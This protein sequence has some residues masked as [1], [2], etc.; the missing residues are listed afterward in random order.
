M[1]V[2]IDLDEEQRRISELE[3]RRLTLS[4]KVAA[5][6][7]ERGSLLGRVHLSEEEPER[8]TAH[9]ALLAE[10]EFEEEQVS[11]ALALL[12]SRFENDANEV[13]AASS[14]ALRAEDAA[15]IEADRKGDRKA[16]VL[17]GQ[18]ADLNDQYQSREQRRREIFGELSAAEPETVAAVR[19][20]YEAE[21]QKVQEQFIG[22]LAEADSITATRIRDIHQ[23][24]PYTSPDDFKLGLDIEVTERGKPVTLVKAP[25][26]ASQAIAAISAW[27]V[28]RWTQAEQDRRSAL[29]E[30]AQRW[31]AASRESGC[32]TPPG[33][34]DPGHDLILDRF[35]ESWL[36]LAP[37]SLRPRFGDALRHLP[38]QPSSRHKTDATH[39]SLEQT[40][41]AAEKAILRRLA[42]P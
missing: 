26:N 41:L 3:Q 28:D 13:K 16:S 23:S 8:L 17:L 20:T 36:A 14:R 40:R 39:W 42:G 21:V 9:D 27:R 18:L 1:T 7:A 10:A 34:G 12:R 30:A 38:E 24:H 31:A 29:T 35:S 33:V 22:D 15:M 6:Q 11:A 37:P 2:A 19:A 5:L 4:E 25:V 32:G